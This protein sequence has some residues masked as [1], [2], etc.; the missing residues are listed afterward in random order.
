MTYSNPSPPAG[1]ARVEAR[2]DAA[3]ADI[4]EKAAALIEPPGAWIQRHWARNAS[5]EVLNW[6]FARGAVCWCADGALEQ[7]IGEADLPTVISLKSRARQF[8]QEV[9]GGDDSGAYYA[10]LVFNDAAGRTQA[11]VVATL[12]KAAELARS[13]GARSGAS[14]TA[15]S[16]ASGTNPK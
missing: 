16:Q 10:L 13:D 1:D 4:L 11:E 14:T 2:P 9:I 3:I 8:V 6:G 5:G 7:A 12:R 15:D